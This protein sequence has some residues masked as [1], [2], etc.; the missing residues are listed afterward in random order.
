MFRGGPYR[1]ASGQCHVQT[2][3][4]GA[5]RV[6]LT[7][8]LNLKFVQEPMSG[9]GIKSSPAFSR[10]PSLLQV[11]LCRYCSRSSRRRQTHFK[12][13]FPTREL[14]RPTRQWT[15]T[16]SPLCLIS[17]LTAILQY[18]KAFHSRCK[19]YEI[20]AIRPNKCIVAKDI[21][22]PVSLENSQSARM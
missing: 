17:I 11:G 14:P 1:L 12:G 13:R 18:N 15:L 7:L 5:C 3:V 2:Y 21:S 9:F 16:P 4:N 20:N 19:A 6:L 22:R 10:W 8:V